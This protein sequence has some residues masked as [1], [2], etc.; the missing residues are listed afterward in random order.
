MM[1]GSLETHASDASTLLTRHF[2]VPIL[3]VWALWGWGDEVGRLAG[4]MGQPECKNPDENRVSR[5]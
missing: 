3:G 2:P 5:A 1:R 4:P